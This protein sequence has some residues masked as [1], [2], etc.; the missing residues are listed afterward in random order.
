MTKTITNFDELRIVLKSKLPEFLAKNNIN[1]VGSNKKR[2]RSFYSDTKDQH[3]S[4]HLFQK[5][6]GTFNYYCFSTNRGG[7]I[8]VANNVI[9]NAPLLGHEFITHN[10]KPLCEM[11]DIEYNFKPLS[12]EEIEEMNIKSIYSI[13][14]DISVNNL[15]LQISKGDKH[16]INSSVVSYMLEKELFSIETVKTYSLGYIPSWNDMAVQLEQR[17]ISKDYLRKV[18]IREFIFN[19][20]NLLFAQFDEHNGIKSFGARN[21]AY[22]KENNAGSKYYNIEN[23]LIYNKRK[24][25]Y[26]LNRSLKRRNSI[27]ASLYICE[28]YLDAITLDKAGFRSAALCSTS[29][30]DDHISL[31]QKVGQTDI[32]LILDGDQAGIKNTTRIITEVMKGIR[33]F[34]V[35]IVTLPDGEDPD[36]F[37]RKHSPQELL[38]LKHIT[39]FEW[40]LERYKDQTDLDGYE[41]AKEMI[42]LIVNESSNIQRDRMCK[43]VSMICDVPIQ[44]IRKEVDAISDSFKIKIQAE[45]ESII[46]NTMKQLKKSPKDALTIFNSA[47]ESIRQIHVATG[48]DLFGGEEF[49]N[50]LFSIKNYQESGVDSDYFKFWRMPRFEMKLKGTMPG[51]LLAIG[52]HPNTGKTTL[53]VNLTI[54]MLKAHLAAPNWG[55][56]ADPSRENDICIFYHTTDDSRRDIVLRFIA[57]LAFEISSEATINVINNPDIFDLKDRARL[58]FA[59]DEAYKTLI[60]WAQEERLV[61]KDS[62]LGS[63]LAVAD[64]VL[65]H[66]KEKYPNRSIVYIA[67]NI[68]NYNDFEGMEDVPRMK[69]LI[70]TIKTEIVVPMNI[71]AITTVEYKKAEKGNNSKGSWQSLNELVSG[72]KAI[73]YR[74]DWMCHLWND[75]YVAEKSSKLW[76]YDWT[77]PEEDWTDS[78]K[79]PIIKM[80]VSK[81]KISGWKGELHYILLGK[82]STYYELTKEDVLELPQDV[83]DDLLKW[84]RDRNPIDH[85][86]GFLNKLGEEIEPNYMIGPDIAFEDDDDDYLDIAV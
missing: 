47:V 36:S 81:N 6:D 25:L 50:E 21:C 4:L 35:R 11:F 61:I 29:F 75:L 26:N 46:D 84:Y 79:C 59:R 60:R 48:K 16:T 65:R 78:D 10:V 82:Q 49:V 44:T 57:A 76:V 15:L 9:N 56:E 40:E 18:G 37:L 54:S 45:Q 67:D 64:G 5:Q 71:T 80:I 34:R 52:G 66:L 68:F 70:T 23:N 72:S 77:V 8:F 62:S 30:T 12:P 74:A 51:K 32:V 3:P 43:Q 14:K 58:L 41:I 53:M 42:P 17:G 31:L 20:N 83:Q 73:E 85:N 39:P 28:G 24:F 22:V 63:N 33:N 38:A 55:Q 69:K 13:V 27:S 2:Y 1:P 19:E 86:K 7:D